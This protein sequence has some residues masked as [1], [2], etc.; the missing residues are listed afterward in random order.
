MEFLLNETILAKISTEKC[1]QACENA[2][3]GF[4]RKDCTDVDESSSQEKPIDT[5]KNL[6][7]FQKENEQLVTV[8]GVDTEVTEGT[9]ELIEGKCI[10]SNETE[11]IKKSSSNST[12]N[13]DDY[14]RTSEYA[15]LHQEMPDND[16]QNLKTQM[17]DMCEQEN[18]TFTSSDNDQN[19]LCEKTE[20]AHNTYVYQE[21]NACA[22]MLN[23]DKE[24]MNSSLNDFNNDS[25][26][27]SILP[28]KQTFDTSF[29]SRNSLH[30][31]P[32]VENNQDICLKTEKENQD[33]TVPK[34]SIDELSDEEQIHD[35]CQSNAIYCT[36]NGNVVQMCS[37]DFQNLKS[38]SVCTSIEISRSSELGI[39][40]E[41]QKNDKPKVWNEM[42]GGI[43]VSTV[44]CPD[45]DESFT[46][47]YVSG[48]SLESDSLKSEKFQ[49]S[50]R[51]SSDSFVSQCSVQRPNQAVNY[52]S[53]A[54]LSGNVTSS[55]DFTGKKSSTIN[56]QEKQEKKLL[57]KSCTGTQKI[58][59][60]KCNDNEAPKCGK[61]EQQKKERVIKRNL[62]KFFEHA[63]RR[64]HRSVKRILRRTIGH[65]R[66]VRYTGMEIYPALNPVTQFPARTDI[67]TDNSETETRQQNHTVG[68][69]NAASINIF[70]P[71]TTSFEPPNKTSLQPYFTRVLNGADVT[72]EEQMQYEMLRVQSF[73]DL[74][75][76]CPVSPLKMAKTGFFSSGKSGEVTCFSCDVRYKNWKKFDN[77]QE[78]HRRISPGCS[79][80]NGRESRNIPVSPQQNGIIYSENQ[81]TLAN[82]AITNE[83]QSQ[84]N[85]DGGSSIQTN[86]HASYQ[87]NIQARNQISNNN[88]ADSTSRQQ[89][90][91]AVQEAM[92]QPAEIQQ[93]IRPPSVDRAHSV[94]EG[95]QNRPAHRDMA[96]DLGIT[97]ER[98]KYPAYAQLNVRVSTFQG[99]PGY[100]DQAPRDMA[101]A[102]FFY[103]GY[104]DYC[105]CFFCGGGLRN[106]DA[107]DDPWVEHARWFSKCPFVRQ[108]RGHRF[109]EIIV[110]R[111]AEMQASGASGSAKN[112]TAVTTQSEIEAR[113]QVTSQGTTETQTTQSETASSNRDPATESVRDMG[114]TD[115]MIKRAI[116]NIK[117]N[118]P[119]KEK[120]EATEILEMIFTIADDDTTTQTN[121]A[122]VS[123]NTPSSAFRSSQ[124]SIQPSVRTTTS[125]AHTATS[126]VPASTSESSLPS[127][128]VSS[129]ETANAAASGGKH[130][131]SSASKEITENE[132]RSLQEENT[133][134]KEQVMC[135]ICMDK[136]VSIAFLPCGHL[137]CCIDC[138]P[139]MRKCPMCR[140]YIKGTVKTYL[141]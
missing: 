80:V 45:S 98:P 101:L 47:S 72:S 33:E 11:K 131:Q 108:N 58:V 59:F 8:K 121:T 24:Q 57:V 51:S 55:I 83:F 42:L 122:V 76:S 137:A 136:N 53:A 124:A 38:N 69:A 22:D 130:Q 67:G 61:A 50:L 44:E 140:V 95:E 21:E 82:V 41:S 31:S 48:E 52:V 1:T 70:R 20:E 75:A 3:C 54:N 94:L 74:P 90:P 117:Q 13:I 115:E 68:G 86:G 84:A 40:R 30:S 104:N 89:Q 92:R 77:P 93:S 107:G 15:D 60:S 81:D 6:D 139:A 32:G 134:L 35:N 110:K 65:H 135:K 120:I 46:K 112:Q 118:N 64:R 12:D 28:Q 123:E 25:Q 127:L 100:L 39:V 10:N 99:W 97:L 26:S 5:K 96:E 79:M 49:S 73:Q 133:Q 119:G 14:Y 113:P 111:Q 66:R 138:A 109:V 132:I 85:Q 102:G 18:S 37:D 105:R 9:F 43:L 87:S 34:L 16:S 116:D 78:V 114:Y 141:A 23:T 27:S 17:E 29:V 128:S 91:Y 62:N 129:L 7:D 71:P 36:S 126:S 125:Q 88:V 4:N 63:G 106:W 2:K 56:L 103:A 19:S